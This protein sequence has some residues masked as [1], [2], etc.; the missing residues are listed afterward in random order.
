MSLDIGTNIPASYSTDISASVLL[1][2]D[3][4]SRKFVVDWVENNSNSN[5]TGG[6]STIVSSD[7]TASRALVSNASG[8]VAVATT[9]LA[10]IGYVNGVTSSIQTQLNSKEN[11]ISLGTTL[12]Y[13]RGDKSWQTLNTSIVPESTNL[14][15]TNTRVRDFLLSSGTPTNGYVLGTNGSTVYWVENSGISIANN[16]FSWDNGNS[17]YE[18]YTV[19]TNG[20]FYINA[21]DPNNVDVTLKFDGD[22][23]VSD[24]TA[25]SFVICEGL[26]ANTVQASSITDLSQ[27]V[28]NP[29][30]TENNYV[31]GTSSAV[32]GVILSIRN[33]AVEVLSVNGSGDITSSGDLSCVDITSTTIESTDITATQY[34]YLGTKWRFSIS[35][36]DDSLQFEYS[37]DGG[38][39]WTVKSQVE[40]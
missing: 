1:D 12:Q 10:E 28:L 29:A 22:F 6:A 35:G 15:Y 14:Y 2:N 17:Y 20:C 21:E 18:P 38:D 40:A 5:I 24:L 11:S 25:M 8:K 39:T 3:I 33:N 30:E 7:L 13:Y 26:T 4:P 9:T 31:F 19:R 32:S 37:N 16:I 36:V 34:Y 27:M 23:V